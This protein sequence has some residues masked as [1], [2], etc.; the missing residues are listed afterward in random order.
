MRPWHYW[1]SPPRA[2]DLP[3]PAP[4]CHVLWHYTVGA[5]VLTCPSYCSAISL[6]LCSTPCRKPFALVGTLWAIFVGP[7]LQSAHHSAFPSVSS[8]TQ[9]ICIWNVPPFHHLPGLDAI[10]LLARPLIHAPKALPCQLCSLPLH[11]SFDP[12]ILL[13]QSLNRLP[14]LISST[15]QALVAKHS[16]LLRLMPLNNDFP[17]IQGPATQSFP[18]RSPA[19]T[20]P[21]QPTG[22]PQTRRRQSTRLEVNIAVRVAQLRLDLVAL[23]LASINSLS[24]HVPHLTDRRLD[25]TPFQNL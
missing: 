2:R 1:S 21:D 12:E 9:I 15:H 22:P 7:I 18:S 19:S 5:N 16:R 20:W 6:A 25:S 11:A 8:L 3:T 4:F 10:I 17:A 24:S 14:H 23:S 13:R